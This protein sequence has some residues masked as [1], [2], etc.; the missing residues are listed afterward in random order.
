MKIKSFFISLYL[1][2]YKYKLFMNQPSQIVDLLAF[3]NHQKELIIIE[4]N[5]KIHNSLKSKFQY[6]Q[7]EDKIE[8]ITIVGG[9]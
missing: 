1:N 8:I 9:G 7:Q 6:I 5:G 3:F 2:G 4:H